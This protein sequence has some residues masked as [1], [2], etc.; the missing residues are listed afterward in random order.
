MLFI[1]LIFWR[2][3]RTYYVRRKK[4]APGKQR[5]FIF[6]RTGSA[7]RSNPF[8]L[9]FTIFDRKKC[10]TPFGHLLLPNCTPFL[11]RTLHSLTTVNTWSFLYEQI[12]KPGSFLPE[13]STASPFCVFNRKKWQISLRLSLKN[14]IALNNALPL[15]KKSGLLLYHLVL[16]PK[17][18]N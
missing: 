18:S 1:K 5:F 6:I 3:R 12:T 13:D 14:S 11:V 7:Q 9:L 16:T 15:K 2:Y 10:Y 4:F 17:R 8:S